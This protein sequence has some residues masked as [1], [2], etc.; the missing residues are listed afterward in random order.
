MFYEKQ[1]HRIWDHN[2][3]GWTMRPAEKSEGDS[4]PSIVLSVV[5]SQNHKR[6]L[7]SVGMMF[8]PLNGKGYDYLVE[9]EG[10]EWRV[11]AIES[12]WIS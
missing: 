10:G 2:S 4:L 9:Q 5:F 11:K 8:G 3:G 6:A 1:S 12:T 7:V